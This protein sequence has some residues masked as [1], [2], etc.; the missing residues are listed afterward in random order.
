MTVSDW[1][2]LLFLSLLWGGSFF[3]TEIALRELTP[4]ILVWSR[5]SLAAIALIVFAYVRGYQLSQYLH[6]WRRF[7]VMGLLNNL[8]P[9]SLIVWGQ[10]QINSSL[11]AILNATT[12]LFTVVLAHLLTHDERL[13]SSR[14]LGVLLGFAG[15]VVLLGPAALIGFSL[16][17]LGQLAVVAAACCYGFAGL[18]GRQFR[19]V[20]PIVTGAGMLTSTSVMLLPLVVSLTPPWQV[21]FSAPTTWAMMSLAL[22]STALAYIIYFRILG[23]AGATNVMLVTFLIPVSALLLGTLLLD[24]T[25]DSTTLFS[26]SLIFAGLVAVDGRLFR[27]FRAFSQEANDDV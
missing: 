27:H 24:E 2:L 22:L 5:V 8:I 25:I 3:F 18:Y 16:S 1:G 7:L 14:L 19:S 20:P 11:A 21:R 6:L 10:T 12:P 9:F 4:L 26:M 15:I 17:N 23:R 13:T